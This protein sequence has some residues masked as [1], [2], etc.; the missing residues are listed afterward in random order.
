MRSEYILNGCIVF[1]REEDGSYSDVNSVK[2]RDGPIIPTG[3]HYKVDRQLTDRTRENA[4]FLSV[5][6]QFNDKQLL[7]V[8]NWFRSQLRTPVVRG[9]RTSAL[10]LPPRSLKMTPRGASI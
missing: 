1:L 8:Y 4:L 5:A 9:L 3:E 7:D 2:R 6:A 10:K